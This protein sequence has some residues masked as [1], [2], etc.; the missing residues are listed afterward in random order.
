VK[1]FR[2]HAHCRDCSTGRRSQR[3]PG[4]GWQARRGGKTAES[5]VEKINEKPAAEPKPA[6]AEEPAK[7]L[8]AKESPV[9][10][11]TGMLKA[12]PLARRMAAESSIDLGTIKGSGP[13]GRIVKKDVEQARAGGPAVKPAAEP[14]GRPA[15]EGK[16]R[17]ALTN[18][19]SRRSGSRRRARA[20]G[21]ARAII[22]K[23]MT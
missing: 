18:L 4:S 8:P 11:D 5:K 13:G 12:S 19:D 6:P 17:L 15:E 9:T 22:G 14:V 23:R 1:W 2:W 21:E 20:A 3:Y 16:S 7:L 10:E